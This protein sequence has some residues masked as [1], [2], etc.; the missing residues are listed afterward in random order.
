M[1]II[2]SVD[3]TIAYTSLP[4]TRL[5]FSADDLVMIAVT[6]TPGLIYTVTS[7]FTEPT[8]IRY[9]TN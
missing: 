5:R 7:V 3:L 6:S 4:S 8:A 1:A 2:T 9:N